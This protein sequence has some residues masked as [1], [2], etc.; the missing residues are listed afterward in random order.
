VPIRARVGAY[1]EAAA[2]EESWL[3]HAPDGLDLAAAATLPL[4]GLTAAQGLAIL[5]PSPESTLLVTGVSG[6]VGWFAAQLAVRAGGR[7]LALA[8]HGDE[9]WARR[10]GTEALPRGTDL[11]GA[12]P[13]DH[14]LDAVPLGPAVA[15]ALRK[16]GMAVFTRPPQDPAPDGVT[17]ETVWVEPDAAGL[18]RLAADLAAGRLVT[19]IAEVIP[20]A[21]A[22]RAHALAE[23]GGARG[24]LVLATAG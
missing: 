21:E 24:K 10:L 2:V 11:A 9:A 4:S 22:A 3:A 1:A 7:V 13:V 16:G 15:A 20:L 8:S 19:R 18:E 23:R 12:G 5:N 17:F 6:A 14:V